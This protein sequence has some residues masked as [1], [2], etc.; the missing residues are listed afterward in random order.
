[1]SRMKKIEELS[2]MAISIKSLAEAYKKTE[3]EDE[4]TAKMKAAAEKMAKNA[5]PD[6]EDRQ[7]EL[8]PKFLDQMIQI[9]NQEKESGHEVDP[10]DW[11]LEDFDI[12]KIGLSKEELSNLEDKK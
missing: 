7:A 2:E 11:E 6:D 5:V 10:S 8:A 3:D 4:A 12:S 9:V 1:M